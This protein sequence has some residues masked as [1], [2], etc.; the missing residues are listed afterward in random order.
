M[1]PVHAPHYIEVY[2]VP[3]KTKATQIHA[4]Y[5]A[6]HNKETGEE[7]CGSVRERASY[8]PRDGLLFVIDRAVILLCN[9]G[10]ANGHRDS[11]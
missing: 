10:H 1:P 9:L 3:L 5:G 6:R 11:G 7:I 2:F 8:S 4:P